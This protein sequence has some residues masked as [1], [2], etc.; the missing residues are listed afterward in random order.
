MTLVHNEQIF[1][2]LYFKSRHCRSHEKKTNSHN[3]T[4][5]SMI[6]CKHEKTLS[7][8]RARASFLIHTHTD[9]RVYIACLPSTAL[10]HNPNAI[11]AYFIG[12][13]LK[14][15]EPVTR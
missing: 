1:T 7:D 2:Y 9:V 12:L 8:L 11:F 6:T 13:T 14:T 3:F 15:K 4:L 10:C 5:A